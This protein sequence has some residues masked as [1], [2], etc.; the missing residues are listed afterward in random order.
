MIG[1][2]LEHTRVFYFR[3]GD[4]DEDEALYLQRRLDERNM[5]RRIELAWP[6]AAGPLRQRVIDE[7]LV[8]YLLDT[9][10]AWQQDAHGASSPGRSRGIS[11][12]AAPGPLVRRWPGQAP[13]S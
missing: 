8:P 3:W 1:R 10:D 6:I 9:R 2:L 13:P 4:T 5:Q 12:Q 11:A 7:A